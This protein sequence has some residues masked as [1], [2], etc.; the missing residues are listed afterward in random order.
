MGMNKKDKRIITTLLI[1]GSFSNP[2]VHN[3]YIATSRKLDRVIKNNPQ[4]ANVLELELD[5]LRKTIKTF[6]RLY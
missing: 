3:D 1:T 4:V 2:I 5:K 6:I